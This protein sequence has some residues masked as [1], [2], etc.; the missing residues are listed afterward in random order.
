VRLRTPAGEVD[1]VAID[2]AEVVCVEVKTGRRCFRG[3]GPGRRLGPRR[4]RRLGRSAAWLGAREGRRGRA[5][6][7]EV[8]YGDRGPPEI[9]HLRDLAAPDRA[10]SGAAF[11]DPDGEG[12]MVLL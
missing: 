11:L 3:R 2:G 5:D 12:P 1:L 10:G 6:L 9:R 4:L 7:L 8:I